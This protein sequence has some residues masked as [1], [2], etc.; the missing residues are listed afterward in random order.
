[1]FL[2]LASLTFNKFGASMNTATALSNITKTK[3]V[4]N[5]Q[6]VPI[7]GREHEMIQNSD[8]S[9]VFSISDKSFIERFLII[10]TVQGN[11][12]TK[13]GALTNDSVKALHAI[14]QKDGKLFVDTIIEVSISGRAKNNDYALLALAY[15]MAEGND[16]TK[17]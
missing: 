7:K 17:R 15:A 1:V 16:K 10:G 13:G 6:Q 9:Y 8:A 4:I 11:Y 2:F 3:N 14:L 5:L 12:Y